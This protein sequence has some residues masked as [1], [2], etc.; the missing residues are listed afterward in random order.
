MDPKMGHQY[1]KPVSKGRAPDSLAIARH[2]HRR[3]GIMVIG[4][5]RGTWPGNAHGVG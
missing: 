2:L 1:Q 5:D 4:I 3:R